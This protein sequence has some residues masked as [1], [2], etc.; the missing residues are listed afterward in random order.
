MATQTEKTIN[1]FYCYA[2]QD[3][4]FCNELDLHLSVLKRSRMIKTWSDRD[5]S[6]G[7]DW[8][9]EIA[10]RLN[11]ADIIL[12]LISP[13]FMMSD[14]AFGVEMRRAM[15]RSKRGEAT[16]IPILL[17][18][19]ADW[20]LAPFGQLQ[21][22]PTGA[23]PVTVWE[24]RDAA[25]AE[26]AQGIRIVVNNLQKSLEAQVQW[27]D[28]GNKLMQYGQYQEALTAYEQ[29]FKLEPDNI[30]AYIG[31]GNA[32]RSLGRVTEALMIYEEAIRLAPTNVAVQIG[33]GNAL[34]D[35]GRFTEALTAYRRA[36]GLEPDNATIHTGIG[37]TLSNLYRY[38]EALTAY[39]QALRLSPDAKLYI[40][41]GNILRTL[42]RYEEA[43][44]AYE[45]ALRL[46]PQDA[47][48]YLYRGDILLYLHQYQESLV[49]YH[50]ALRLDP[51]N[52]PAYLGSGS[53]HL[54]LRQYEEA[55]AAYDAAIV[56][57]PNNASSYLAKARVL[58]NLGQTET[59][60]LAYE[61]ARKL[62]LNVEHD[63]FLHE[64][65]IKTAEVQPLDTRIEFAQHFL[66]NAGFEFHQLP[67]EVGFLAIA[68]TSLWRR[69]FPR[70]MYVRVFFDSSLDQRTVS[71]IYQ[72]AKIHSDHS[73]VIINQQP[74]LSAWGEINILR[75]EQGQRHFVCLPIEES[76]IQ[77]SIALHNELLT[78]QNYIYVRLGRG[79]DPY[80]VRD[81]VSGA[82]SFF[83]RQG[84]TEELLDAL[85]RRKKIGLFGIQKMGKSSLL[86]EL[87]KRAEFP[88]AYVYL[89]TNDSQDRIYNRIIDDW[90]VNSRVKYPDFKWAKSVSATTAIS[91][92]DFDMATKSLLEYLGTMAETSPL[93]GICLD[94]IEHIV[95]SEGDEKALQLYINLMDSLRGLQQET[96]SIA[97]LVAGVH[98]SIARSN[99]FWGS[100]K[101][102]MHQVIVEHF[103]PPLDKDDCS[104]MIR[105][106]GQQ[107][108]LRYEDSALDY[109]LEMSGSHPF[110]AR[111]ICSIAYKS[112]KD[113]R[114]ISVEVV[115]NV[116]Q[117]F[118]R[119]PTTASYFDERGLWK[120]L[121]LSDLW[122]EEVGNANHLLLIK[123]ASSHQDLPEN[124]LYTGSDKKAMLAAFYALRE[125]S[126]IFSPD[127]SGYYRIT[128]GL[129]RDWIRFHQLG[130]DER[131]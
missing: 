53:L 43:L 19:T 48:A 24:N 122:G 65:N 103:L 77:E 35:L 11:D 26:I 42:E 116:V 36:L 101:N 80:D 49:S 54:E 82:V 96:N 124:E 107:I 3:T 64:A 7:S 8:E 118:I 126:I 74:E 38:E 44:V 27:V 39:E 87:K 128:F 59:A 23:R 114:A 76:L 79:F 104:N 6:A 52:I 60:L 89:D 119:K 30:M 46:S 125:R 100:Q 78:L 84:L 13:D 63:Q 75:G 14:I 68:K 41:K 2:R 109:I 18:P 5:I 9:K 1:I 73:L 20:D 105:S 110:L 83:G 62:G 88:V 85:R 81:P 51:R 91:R 21:A 121:S 129:F 90:V 117:E 25:F 131:G 17:R 66:T 94:E 22:L 45:Q 58:R 127:N 120:E 29:A 40:D 56:L 34:R 67:G 10:Y 37:Y 61:Q 112:R 57:D 33:R 102:P 115:E 99:Y 106:L 93:L 32:L 15:E 113:M 4:K 70:G 86:Y 108:N 50:E 28:E 97:L 12:L 31:R 123:L 16:A 95:P 72:A 71:S 130:I 55:L 111:Q 98:P 47:E 69:S 92:S